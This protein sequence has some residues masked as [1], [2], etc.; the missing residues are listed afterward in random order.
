MLYLIGTG[1]ST[2]KDLTLRSIEILQKC[3]HVF[4]ENYTS[5]TNINFNNLEKLIN[6]KIKFANRNKVES[7]QEILKLAENQIVA[8]LIIG[9][10]LFATTHS[11]II[12]DA[13]EKNI[14]IEIIHNTSIMNV[15]GCF[16]LYSYNFGRTV[17]IPFFDKVK[18]TSFF[19]NIKTNYKN[20]L[21]TLCLLDIKTDENRF[22]SPNIAIEQLL[23]VINEN[24]DNNIFADDYKIFVISRFGCQ[25]EKIYYDTFENLK[26]KNFGEPLHSLI[27]PAQLEVIEKEH[28]EAMFLN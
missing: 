10:P 27:L 14:P 22:M 17:S 8:L 26:T 15:M 2:E 28:V 7:D 1:L 21:H 13:K 9:T 16:G 25:D 20:K 24:P 6:K 5:K 12:M 23:Y 4:L 19:D 18:F 3:D 11:Q